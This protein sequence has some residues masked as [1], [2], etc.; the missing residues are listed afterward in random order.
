METDGGEVLSMAEASRRAGVSMVTMIKWLR[1]GMVPGARR[2]ANRWRWEIPASSI[3][4]I[5]RPRRGRPRQ[6]PAAKLEA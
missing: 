2:A 4:L 1:A 5:S 3:P 6:T